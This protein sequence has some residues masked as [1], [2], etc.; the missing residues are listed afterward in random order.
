MRHRMSLPIGMANTAAQIITLT[1]GWQ[2]R[3]K[4]AADSEW[5]SVASVPTKYVNHELLLV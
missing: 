3:Q 4:D 2:V 5:L 1:K